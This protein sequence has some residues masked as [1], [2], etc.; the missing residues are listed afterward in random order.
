MSWLFYALLAPAILTAVNFV[1]KLI[2]EKHV[3]NP[4]GMPIYAAITAFISGCVLW[5]LTGFPVLTPQDTVLVL[6][7]GMLTS[8]GGAIY[9][10]ALSKEETSKIIF[11]LQIQPVMVLV[12][13]LVFLN[14]DISLEQFIGFVVILTAALALSMNNG[15][16]GFKLSRPFIMIL[17]VDALNAAAIVL[18]K[19]VAADDI[20]RVLAY[21]SWGLALGGLLIY[22]FIAPIRQAFH[23]SLRTVPRRAFA[24]IGVNETVFVIAKLV[25]FTAVSLGP[26]ALVSVLSGVQVFFGIVAGWIL[27]LLL[28]MVYKEDINRQA[29]IR[30]GLLAFV[31]IMGIGLVS[32]LGTFILSGLYD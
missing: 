6:I 18:F 19:F 2:I 21:E 32:E 17:M 26:V 30:K 28:P 20:N 7:T 9:F 14:E 16:A 10:Q 15:L 27:T 24:I 31:M 8:A 3:R 13:S 23:D 29:L 12:I 1:D 4:L 25:T 5:V 22:L 11:F